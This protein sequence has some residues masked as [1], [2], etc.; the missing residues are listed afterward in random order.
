MADLTILV[1]SRGRPAA[2][3]PLTQAVGATCTAGTRLVFVVDESDPEQQDYIDA[4]FEHGAGVM[5][6][7][8]SSMVEALNHAATTIEPEP[9]A[10]AFMGDDHLPRTVAWDTRYLEALEEMGT[11]MVYG[12]DLLQGGKLPTQVAMTTDIIRA[13]GYMAPPELFHLYVD[14]FWLDLGLRAQCIRYLPDVIVEHRHPV[15]GKAAWD[16]GY[17]RVN[18]SR[19]YQRDHDAYEQ[20]K[21]ARLEA[22]VRR[23]QQLRGALR[24]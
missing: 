14:N 13:L 10:V 20:Y 19:V 17:K 18:D 5:A 22:D 4:A 21:T 9:W 16:E 11:G 1:P 3:G 8:S 24:G 12:N 6:W 23:V 2:V 7:D 15:A